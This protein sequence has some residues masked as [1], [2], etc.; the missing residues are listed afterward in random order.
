MM[1]SVLDLFLMFFTY[2]FFGWIM[3]VI[4][5]GFEEKKFVNRG[6]LNGPICPVYG[7]GG[8][9]VVLILTPLKWNPFLLFLCSSLITTTVE[10]VTGAV[11]EKMYHTRWWDYSDKKFNLH[12]HICLAFSILWGFICMFLMYVVQ[13][14][15]FDNFIQKLPDWVKIA[16]LIACAVPFMIDL[17]STVNTLKHLNLNL[18]KID[19]AAKQMHNISDA[20]GMKVYGGA[21]MAM[22]RKE[23]LEQSEKLKE[24][25]AEL[26]ARR[27]QLEQLGEEM[28][29]RQKRIIKAFPTM[30][31]QNYDEAL[32]KV[33]EMINNKLPG[34]KAQK[35]E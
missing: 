22:Q 9:A 6:F 32:A 4:Y 7:V 1:Y 20:I 31:T 14:M 13:P 34:K 3:E 30:K 5:H 28:S 35:A 11:L 26:E 29:R 25:Q 19:E 10:Y 23:E 2:G 18:A 16:A 15:L 33:R 17:V 27:K 8:V 12:G 24:L 21:E